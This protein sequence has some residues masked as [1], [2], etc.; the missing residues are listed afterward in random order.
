MTKYVRCTNC[1][2]KIYIG[3]DVCTSERG[4]FCDAHCFAEYYSQYM[5]L[6]E[7]EA[8]FRTTEIIDEA[9]EIRE[10]NQEI[11]RLKRELTVKQLILNGLTEPF[12]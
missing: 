10:L 4:I 5:T 12:N 6:T 2:K 11:A 1:G 7:K 8:A 9:D 3:D